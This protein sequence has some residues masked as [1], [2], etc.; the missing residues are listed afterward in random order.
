V[1]DDTALAGLIAN[2]DGMRATRRSPRLAEI[3]ATATFLASDGA[4]AIT[5]AF[6]N[7]TSG[8]FV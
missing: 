4:A 8:M 5:G 7:A 3:A 6:I 2:L 1:L